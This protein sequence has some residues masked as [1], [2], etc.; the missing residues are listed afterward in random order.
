[1]YCNDVAPCFFIASH[2]GVTEVASKTKQCSTDVVQRFV[3]AL[4]SVPHFHGVALL[5]RERV[6]VQ[7]KPLVG[8]QG[9]G[10]SAEPRTGVVNVLNGK[11]R[12]F[13]MPTKKPATRV[14][15]GPAVGIDDDLLFGD[16]KMPTLSKITAKKRKEH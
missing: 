7:S 10:S 6:P 4:Q 5:K 2:R 3:S 14:Q 8:G 12:P 1:M 15:E 16:C 11:G 13:Q 9:G